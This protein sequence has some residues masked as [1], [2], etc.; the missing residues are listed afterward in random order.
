MTM[1]PEQDNIDDLIGKVLAGEASSAEE[2]L[3]KNWVAQSDANRQYFNQLK[4]IF[5]KAATPIPAMSFDADKAWVAMKARLHPPEHKN[6][7]FM[8]WNRAARLAAGIV[9]I[10]A[11][12]YLAFQW[13]SKPVEMLNLAS[14][15]TTIERVLPDG[16]AAFLNR[17]TTLDYVHN[18]R[19]GV[20]KVTLNG[21]GFFT[22]E[23]QQEVDFLIEAQEVLVKDIG[24]SFNV[25]AYADRD[26][27]EVLVETGEVQI[28]T[29]TNPGIRLRA[30]ETGIYSKKE[31]KFHR[32]A[33]PDANILAYKTGVLVF[34][35][36][37]L[38]TVINTINE[39]YQAQ[40]KLANE[41][42]ATCRITVS[43]NNDTLDTIVDVIAT[44]LGLQVART[45]T[46]I[47]LEGTGCA[48]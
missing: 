29:L 38:P 17:N 33:K 13:F 3:V 41:N 18:P 24:T 22:V 19:K 37:D 7:R 2:T 30:G 47:I 42:L 46:E 14:G 1:E 21:E 26:T 23:H 10:A 39:V 16:S 9:M 34:K 36:T 43:F 35:N 32:V 11:G 5:K 44:T 20:R 31:K 45:Q 12:G 48:Q 28:Y 40:I 25:S 4:I 6:A 27:I 15:S 8:S